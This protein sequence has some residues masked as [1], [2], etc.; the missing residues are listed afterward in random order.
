M[1]KEID[2]ISCPDLEMVHLRR[3]VEAVETVTKARKRD[4]RRRFGRLY[5]DILFGLSALS[6]SLLD[7]RR[8]EGSGIPAIP[9]GSGDAEG[10]K[11]EVHSCPT[12]QI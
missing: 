9:H 6:P 12:K 5:G 2:G 1:T 7:V 11:N 3:A 10:E 4:F 8:P